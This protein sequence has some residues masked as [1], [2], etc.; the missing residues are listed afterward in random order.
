MISPPPPP[1]RQ[2]H[3][4]RWQQG[5]KRQGTGGRGDGCQGLRALAP[6][7]AAQGNCLAEAGGP[8]ATE[9]IRVVSPLATHLPNLPRA[10]FSPPLPSMLS[11]ITQ[12]QPL[13]PPGHGAGKRYWTPNRRSPPGASTTH[14]PPSNFPRQPPKLSA[15]CH[16]VGSFQE[17]ARE[18][19][20]GEGV[21]LALGNVR[22]TAASLEGTHLV[23]PRGFSVGCLGCARHRHVGFADGVA[24]AGTVTATACRARNMPAHARPGSPRGG[25]NWRLKTPGPARRAHR[26]TVWVLWRPWQ[27]E[28]G[29][30]RRK[31]KE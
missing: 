22:R 31:A 5:G 24:V 19:R 17:E 25:L 21:A 13:G 26:S 20:P 7:S 30:C 15:N 6:V 9:Y 8:P 11:L 4:V 18:E 10:Y 12:R 16:Q 27:P 28:P 14:A 3:A 1:N 2:L 29:C 23:A